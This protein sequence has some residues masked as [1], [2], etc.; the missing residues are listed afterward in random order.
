MEAIESQCLPPTLYVNLIAT[1]I[2]GVRV[3]G[4]DQPDMV[5]IV[6][7]VCTCKFNNTIIDNYITSTVKNCM[8]TINIW[9]ALLDLV[10]KT[11]RSTD[12]SV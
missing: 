5:K 11:K 10:G 4:I 7:I 3:R 6:Y 8:R 1:Y 2:S 9:L 12:F